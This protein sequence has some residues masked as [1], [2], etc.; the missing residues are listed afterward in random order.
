VN[1]TIAPA[2]IITNP[3]GGQ[4]LISC[5]LTSINWTAGGCSGNYRIEYSIDNGATWNIITTSFVTLGTGNC[6]YNSWTLPNTPSTG[7]LVRVSDAN[8]LTTKTDRSDAVFSILPSITILQPNGGISYTI[9]SIANIN[10][11]ST[12]TSGYYNIEYTTN[13]G[14]SWVSIASNQLITNNTFVWTIPNA[15]STNCKVRVTDYASTCKTDMS[16]QVFTIASVIRN[17]EYFDNNIITKSEFKSS[18]IIVYPNPSRDNVI[19]SY[20]TPRE[21]KTIFSI[22]DLSGNMVRL[23]RVFINPSSGIISFLNSIPVGF[24]YFNINYLIRTKM[25]VS[26]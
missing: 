3:N 18:E 4:N 13:G 23:N 19:I 25:A 16:D 17:T 11:N 10:W 14:A 1:F 7:C 5:T 6:V 8:N 20:E 2:I 12:G 24:Y 26:E 15:P 21:C 9:G 22:I